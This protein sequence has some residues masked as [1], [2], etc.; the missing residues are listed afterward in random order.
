ME[1]QAHKDA[2]ID[3][4]ARDW[5]ATRMVYK[6]ISWFDTSTYKT[7]VTL[8]AFQIEDHGGYLPKI[9]IKGLI[10]QGWVY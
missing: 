9:R 10:G 4:Q 1:S 5:N 3:Q 8:Y 2:D 6:M 7:L